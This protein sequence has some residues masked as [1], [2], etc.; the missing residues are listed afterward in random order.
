M[1]LLFGWFYNIADYNVVVKRRLVEPGWV[2]I[3]IE[4][5]SAYLKQPVTI[6]HLLW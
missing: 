6:T 5:K 3:I 4:E 2:I 1:I